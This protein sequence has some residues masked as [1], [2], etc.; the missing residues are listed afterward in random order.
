MD[1]YG[2]SM[3]YKHFPRIYVSDYAERQTVVNKYVFP[4]LTPTPRTLENHSKTFW[5]MT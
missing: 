5:N 4:D 1:F 2:F 3:I